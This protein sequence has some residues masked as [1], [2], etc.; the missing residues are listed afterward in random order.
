MEQSMVD[1]CNAALLRGEVAE[2]PVFSHENHGRTFDRFTLE[3]RRLSGV[4]DRVHVIAEHGLLE[5]MAL[6]KG[7]T[8]EVEG[9]IRSYNNR[10]GQGRRLVITVFATRVTCQDGEPENR[11]FLR[12]RICREPVYR[13]TPLGR[14]ICDLMLAVDRTYGRTD[15]LPCIL[16]GS[17]ARMAAQC[18]RGTELWILGRLQ[19]RTYVKQLETGSE[20]RTAFEISAITADLERYTNPC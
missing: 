5:E 8:V 7:Q 14:E 9:Q 3:V 1:V 16:W 20:E 10:S 15:Y 19:S 6:E 11:V 17:L 13:R 2:G 12:G 4:R 18:A